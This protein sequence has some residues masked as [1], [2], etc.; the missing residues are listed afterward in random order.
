M[1]VHNSKMIIIKKCMLQTNVH[2]K[3]V[4]NFFV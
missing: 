1:N 3:L 2:V 4:D